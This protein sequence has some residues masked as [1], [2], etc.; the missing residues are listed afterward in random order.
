MIRFSQLQQ[1]EFTAKEVV[2]V[3]KSCVNRLSVFVCIYPG[4][5]S[6]FGFAQFLS[7]EAYHN[8]LRG[9]PLY[10]APEM[11]IKRHYDAKVS[12]Q[13]LAAFFIVLFKCELLGGLNS[14]A[15]YRN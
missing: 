15:F 11:L 1:T 10:M 3:N 12:R 13:Q 14:S 6:D 7:D 9:S 4:F 5:V 8:S 2:N